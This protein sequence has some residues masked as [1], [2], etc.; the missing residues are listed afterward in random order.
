MTHRAN[1]FAFTPDLAQ[2]MDWAAV[3][4]TEIRPRQRRRA[5]LRVLGAVVL[6]FGPAV[7]GVMVGV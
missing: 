4:E 3:F 2:G 6:A 7:V 1:T 5:M